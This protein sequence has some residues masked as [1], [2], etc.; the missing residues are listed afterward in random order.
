MTA[1]FVVANL[2]AVAAF[3]A[4]WT[5]GG[6]PERFAVGVLLFDYLTSSLIY[7]S[8][9]HLFALQVA[10]DLVL[11]TIFGWLALRGVRWWPV[12]TAGAL[13]LIVVVHFLT[14]VTPIGRDAVLSARMGLWI[15]I[16]TTLVAGVGERWLA[17][18][19]P[20]SERPQ[21][22]GRVGAAP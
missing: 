14:A 16:Y 8:W 2:V 3:V 9:T 22:R 10:Q 13:A 11:L 6:H 5:R 19:R 1:F 21:W 20:V 15:L 17:G 7:R 12:V 18:E 4:G